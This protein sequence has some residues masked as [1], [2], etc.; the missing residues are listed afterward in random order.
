MDAIR[1]DAQR[2][3]LTKE[4]R[5]AFTGGALYSRRGNRG[6]GSG[7]GRGGLG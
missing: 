7:H 3:I 1:E 4:I 6:R 2:T 5:D